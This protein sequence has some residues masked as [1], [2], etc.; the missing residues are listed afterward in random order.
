MKITS[1]R[2]HY[3]RIP[4]DMGAPKQDFAG[5]R[6]PTMD[7]LLV[8]VETDSGITGWG[9]GFGHSIIPATKTALEAY[10]GPWFIGKDATDINALHAQ[11]AQAFH[12]FG[13]NG[14]VVY[15]HSCVD[16][17]LWD[18]AG[19]RAGLPLSAL[20]G[21][22]RRKEVRAYCSLMRY[23]TP[24]TIGRICA[25][26]VGRGFRHIKLHEIGVDQVKAAR[27]GA[28]PDIAIMNDVNCPWSVAQAM[29]MERAFRPCN[30]AW[31]E[32]PVWPPEDH[33]GLARVRARGATRIAA[34]ENAAGVH[35]FRDMFQKGAI[36]IAQPSVTKIGGIT[37]MRKIIALA[38]AHSVELVPHCAYFG[39]GNLASIHITASLATDTL[40]ENIYANLEANPFGDAMLARDGKVRVPT[41][42]GL[43]VE[44]DMAIVEKYRQGPAGMIR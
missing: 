42:P 15:A 38:E 11:A 32:E 44:P 12:I 20:L 23:A 3:V 9:E 39:P 1:I 30:L 17:A 33:D 36:D 7:H 2:T 18:I 16:I 28:G 6:F 43:G 37:E 24:A 27:E 13:R 25:E 22:A 31:L 8:Q 21:G 10:V 5:L 34:G 26:M 41:G 35:D 19:K 14:P 29:E 40:L 4:F